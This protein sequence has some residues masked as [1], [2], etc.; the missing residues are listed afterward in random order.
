MIM[1]NHL[2]KKNIP[3]VLPVDD[4]LG[5][6]L[7]DII[8]VQRS[9]EE[10]VLSKDTRDSLENF[11]EE[12]RRADILYSYNRK[13]SYKVL[14]NGDVG[15][16]KTMAAEAIAYELNLPLAIVRLDSLI[17]SSLRKTVVNFHK[18]FDFIKNNEMIILFNEFDA[19]AKE[20]FS[21]HDMGELGRTVSV[22]SQMLSFY[23]GKSIILAET[24]YNIIIDRTILKRFD[25]KIRFPLPDYKQILKILK[26]KLRGVKLQFKLDDK[27]LSELFDD[28]SGARI[29]RV[30]RKA[31][32]KM[33][34]NKNESLTI[35]DLEYSIKH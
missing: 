20:R 11:L 15:C 4:D 6:P 26:L 18:I 29:E 33:I 9:L 32:N 34:L 2:V 25:Y 8:T 21:F 30:V 35:Q 22:F 17:S 19:I 10:I 7:L 12:H 27:K 1:N 5:I 16:G 13:P 14:F 28:Y 24:N 31:I 3:S 23:Q